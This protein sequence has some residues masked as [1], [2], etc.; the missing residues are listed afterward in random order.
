ML[1]L[2]YTLY[3]ISHTI[4]TKIKPYQNESAF[5]YAQDATYLEKL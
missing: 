5:R 4:E 3:H 2:K 1:A